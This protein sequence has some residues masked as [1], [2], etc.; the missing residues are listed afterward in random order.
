M[1]RHVTSAC[2]A[3]I[4]CGEGL[5]RPTSCN[6]KTSCIADARAFEICAKELY[7]DLG[8]MSA[9]ATPEA[10]V[11]VVITIRVQRCLGAFD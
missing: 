2:I 6:K 7:S 10:E 9:N 3:R 1:Y 8:P 11:N 5:R 4:T